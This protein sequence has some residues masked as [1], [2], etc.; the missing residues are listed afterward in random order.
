MKAKTMMK[1]REISGWAL[2]AAMLA[3]VLGVGSLGINTAQAVSG[4]DGVSGGDPLAVKAEKFPDPGKLRSAVELLRSKIES[5][6]LDSRLKTLLIGDLDQVHREE[7]YLYIPE[8]IVLGHSRFDGDYSTLV[9]SG[10]FTLAQRG[11]PIYFS[12]R[13]RE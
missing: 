9:S 12:K 3:W 11:A 2:A 7:K 8:M 4:N 6:P 5:S 13:W 10:A 1:K